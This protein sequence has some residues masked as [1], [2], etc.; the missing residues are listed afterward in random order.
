MIRYIRISSLF[1]IFS[2]FVMILMSCTNSRN[3]ATEKTVFAFYYNWYGNVDYN[4][5][6]IHWAHP[7]IAGGKDAKSVDYIPGGSDI[8]ANYYPELKNYSS[9]DTTVISIHMDMMARA[10]IDVAVVTWWGINDFGASALPV[11]FREA[12]K[13]NIKVCFHIEPYAKRSAE[14][15]RQDIAFL[16]ERFGNSSSFYRMNGKPCFF[17]YDSYLTP[18]SEW[19]RLCS[20]EGDL[21]IRG[22]NLDSNV[23]GL[24]VSEKEEDSFLEAGFD[25]LYTYFAAS[26]FTY[27]STPANWLYMQDW[28]M[29]NG[30]IFIPCVGPGYIDTRIR[31]WNGSTTRNR[32]NGEYYAEMFQAAVESGAS[33]IGITSFNEWHEGTQ[34]EPAI[35]FEC[36]TFKYLDYLPQSP[37]Y[38]LNRTS[39][40]VLKW[41]EGK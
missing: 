27:G 37:D 13:R 20:V 4:G 23:I 32:D 30:K 36:E 24:W 31:P 10:K 34:I 39:E 9:T 12:S 5:K 7:V 2:A 29:K 26:G 33:C 40:F 25:G 14:S 18:A 21:T 22:T 16:I 35:P 11:I 28:A 15:V 41:K 17:I 1:I 38:Y 8:A 6:E 19:S 3:V